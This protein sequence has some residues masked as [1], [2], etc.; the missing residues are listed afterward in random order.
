MQTLDIDNGNYRPST[1]EDLHNFTK[2]QDTLANISWYTRCCIATDV[3]DT[4]DLDVNTA[5]ALIKNT[6]KPVATSFT[7]AEHVKPV[8]YTHLTLPTILLV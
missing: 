5:Y 7:L 1:L 8:S 3:P 6:T 2:L 4:Y